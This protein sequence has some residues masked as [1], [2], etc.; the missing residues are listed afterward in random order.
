MSHV[1]S[2]DPISVILKLIMNDQ[3]QSLESRCRNVCCSTADRSWPAMLE[4]ISGSS[5]KVSRAR[6]G[7]LVNIDCADVVRPIQVSVPPLAPGRGLKIQLVTNAGQSSKSH[8]Y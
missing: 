8:L 2:A 1:D 4:D 5:V 3:Y 6:R 7:A